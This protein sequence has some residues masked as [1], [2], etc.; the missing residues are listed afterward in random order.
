MGIHIGE[1]ADMNQLVARSIVVMWLL[2]ACAGCGS[3]SLSQVKQFGVASSSLGDH[4][5]KAFDL[6]STA[7]VD[8]NIYD[9]AGDPQ[10]GPT[11]S[12]F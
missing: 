1:N 3:A 7:S 4:A 6:A 8:R 9:I 2:V 11:D 10:K 12:T 5:R